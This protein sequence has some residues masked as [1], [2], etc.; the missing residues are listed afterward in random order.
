MI[1][2]LLSKAQR[3]FESSLTPADKAVF[4]ADLIESREREFALKEE[5]ALKDRDLAYK[6]ELALKDRE[7]KDLLKTQIQEL[8]LKLQGLQAQTD[9]LK[10]T[11]EAR[12]IM[13]NFEIFTTLKSPKK[14]RAER[15][16]DS[17][18]ET[19]RLHAKLMEIENMDWPAK[20]GEIYSTLSQRIH[21]QSIESGLEEF[22]LRVSTKLPAYI[23]GLIH[24]LSM[25][26]YGDKVNVVTAD[27][28]SKTKRKTGKK[29]S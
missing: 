9:F 18:K 27:I 22:I 5:L 3:I 17:L 25:E 7:A 16:A 4:L 19:P 8:Q 21:S 20:A 11:L 6:E 15:W 23:V 14:P 10:G 26:F 28:I 24:V 13:E 29:K 1:S 2:S 12:H